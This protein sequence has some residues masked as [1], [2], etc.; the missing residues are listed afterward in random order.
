MNDQ[1][2]QIET[3]FQ[4]A[5]TSYVTGT[6]KALGLGAGAVTVDVTTVPASAC[7]ALDWRLRRHPGRDLALI[8]DEVHGW[9]ATIETACGE[10]MIVLAY[11]GGPDVLPD[12]RHVVRFLAALRGGDEPPPGGAVPVL[13]TGGRHE[14]LLP[15][16]T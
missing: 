12:A 13:R 7:V 16:L 3:R 1:N 6:A 15:L 2:D 10:D 8:W 4:R 11:L 9:A 5:L 14:E